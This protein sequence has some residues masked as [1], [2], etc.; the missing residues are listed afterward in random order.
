MK[1]VTF[2]TAGEPRQ[3][4]G[5]MAG[6]DAVCELPAEET[7]AFADM[8]ALIDGGADALAQARAALD[9]AGRVHALA[10][11]RLLAPLPVPRQ[12]RDCLSFEQHVRQVRANRH[13]LGIGGF[14]SDPAKV[15]IPQVWY[16]QPIYYK[17]NRFSVVGPQ[18]DVVIPYGEDWFDYELEFAAVIGTGGRDLPRAGA[19]AHI[20]GYCIFN[21]FSARRTQIREMA[22]SLGPAKGKDFDTGNVLGPWL[23][24]ADEIA[25]PYAL[26]MVARVNGEEWSRGT[27][28]AMHHR[29]DA[30]LEHVSRDE[31]IH[32]GEIFGSGTVGSGCGMEVG[33]FLKPGD[34]V[35]LEVDGLGVLR[36]R[37]V[38]KPS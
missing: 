10:D 22:G 9:R 1:L 38:A 3:R 31:T 20:F 21:D 25:D 34:V 8:L 30:I 19:H 35:E 29:F 2:Q 33:R 18:A 23:V 11:I 4:I 32:P 5:A 24:T 36:N 28:A 26:T 15:E 14:P 12:M 37:V 17:A 16:D 7:P 6:D 13:L 27:S